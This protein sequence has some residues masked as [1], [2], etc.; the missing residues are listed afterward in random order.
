[1][2]A[3]ANVP[4]YSLMPITATPDD[5]EEGTFED[6][7]TEATGGGPPE[8]KKPTPS[9][10]V[11][12]PSKRHTGGKKGVRKPS[13]LLRA[14]RWVFENPSVIGEDLTPEQQQCRELQEGN[15]LEFLKM[16]KD[17]EGKLAMGKK[18]DS[19]GTSSVTGLASGSPGRVGGVDQGSQKV[20]GL[21]KE[22]LARMAT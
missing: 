4:Y 22:L 1:M 9:G 16:L 13:K 21:I 2:E 12:D 17:M 3:R 14:L 11:T 18:G 5:D 8:P 10:F 6:D 7:G 19:G 20:Q 15:P